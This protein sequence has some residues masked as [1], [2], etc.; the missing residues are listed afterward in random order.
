VR[1]C[2]SARGA[3]VQRLRGA[4]RKRGVAGA[5][6]ANLR[7]SITFKHQR[8]HQPNGVA[9]WRRVTK[10]AAFVLCLCQRASSLLWQ[11]W[12]GCARASAAGPD[13]R[14]RLKG[15]TQ[16]AAPS[17]RHPPSPLLSLGALA[18]VSAGRRADR[19]TIR[20]RPATVWFKGKL[21]GARRPMAAASPPCEAWHP[22]NSKHSRQ[23]SHGQWGLA[24]RDVTQS[25][26]WNYDQSTEKETSCDPQH[27]LQPLLR[28]CPPLSQIFRYDGYVACWGDQNHGRRN[29]QHDLLFLCGH[30]DLSTDCVRL[31]SAQCPMEIEGSV[32]LSFLILMPS[33]HAPCPRSVRLA[34]IKPTELLN[35]F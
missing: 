31:N 14:Q 4:L 2:S 23:A 8:P 29:L 19:R 21:F 5:R 12:L 35:P 3:Q 25:R 17:S 9:V 16:S 7:P 1:G 20:E 34:V 24:C 30:Q 32:D 6:S 13:C 26:F 27:C 18:P 10:D 11:S 22:I 28:A 33:H 15:S